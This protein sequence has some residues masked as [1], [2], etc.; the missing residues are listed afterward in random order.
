MSS[1]VLFELYTALMMM[2]MMMM[3]MIILAQGYCEEKTSFNTRSWNMK[4]LIG[5]ISA[6]KLVGQLWP[7]SS[8]GPEMK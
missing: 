2:M 1:P 3:M 5:A 7:A 6:S 8:L 4:L